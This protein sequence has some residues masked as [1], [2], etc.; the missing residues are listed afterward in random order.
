MGS[1][2]CFDMEHGGLFVL[3]NFFAK[4]VTATAQNYMKKQQEKE[5]VH[6]L[7]CS[8]KEIKLNTSTSSWLV[9]QWKYNVIFGRRINVSVQT[10]Y[11]W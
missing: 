9:G 3:I 1:I 2:I 5:L 10:L 8:N 11:R 4:I 6:S 7:S